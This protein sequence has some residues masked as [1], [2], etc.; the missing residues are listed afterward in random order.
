MIIPLKSGSYI[1][2]VR[3]KEKQIL[4]MSLKQLYVKALQLI[5]LNIEEGVELYTQAPVEELMFIAN[6]LR[7]IH[8]PGNIV[9]WMIDRNVN[10]TNICFSQCTF[11]NFCRKKGSTD[12]YV[13]ST[14]DYITKIDE[15]YA[16]GGDQLLLQGGM[17][18]D[19]GISFYIEL[20]KTLKELYPTLKLHA[21][22]PPEIVFL[23]KKE[24]LSFADVLSRLIDAGLDSLPGAGAEIL[25]DR[26]RK[27]VSPAK[28]T[29]DEWLDIMK[30]AHILNL[31]TSATMMYGHIET[32]EERIEHLIRLR[33]LQ[34]KKPANH[35][36]FITFIP[37][38]FQDERT[39]LLQKHGIKSSYNGPDYIRMIAISRIILNNIRNIQASILTVGKDIGMLSLHSGANDL[40]S[41]MIEENVVSAAGSTN[42]FNSDEMQSIIKEAGFVPGRRNQKY[43]L[44]HSPSAGS[45]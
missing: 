38:P 5:P 3:F 37:W 13:T 14:E 23:A 4:T 27:I 20:F 11:C 18:P 41:V 42:R 7:Q 15:L 26:V 40:G 9:G 22:G 17:N 45:I 6:R 16:L 43:E 30:E 33:D 35:Y 12:A 10:L 31:P 25:S 34:D 8:N 44:L 36:G 32:T 19:L 2:H 24:R 28:A 1:L 29:S 39:V 21:L